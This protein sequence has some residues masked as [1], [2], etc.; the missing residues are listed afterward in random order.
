MLTHISVCVSECECM[1]ECVCVGVGG[2][3]ERRAKGAVR[4]PSGG[5]CSSEGGWN[6]PWLRWRGTKIWK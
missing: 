2:W 5:S 3:E 1:C 4:A 6:Q